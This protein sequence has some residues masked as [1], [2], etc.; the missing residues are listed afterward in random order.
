MSSI[1]THVGSACVADERSA[2]KYE[3]SAARFRHKG[4]NTGSI[5]ARCNVTNPLDNGGNPNWDLL[6]VVYFKQV[7]TSRVIVQLVRV[8]NST[9]GVYT[10]ET[11]DTDDPSY[12]NTSPTA[13][14]RNKFFDYTFDFE[15]FAYFIEI[16]VRRESNTEED[17]PAVSIVRLKQGFG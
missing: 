13:Q 1:W 12:D 16:K 17:I 10:I 4:S 15:K 9:G 8:S 3:A 5:T 11:F 6:E 7:E 2:G 14:T